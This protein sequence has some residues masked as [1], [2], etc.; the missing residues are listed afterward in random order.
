M[1]IKGANKKPK[2]NKSKSK[3]KTRPKHRNG[4]GDSPR[5]NQSNEFRNNYDS[6][7]WSN[8]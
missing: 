6:I 1:E 2:S 8:K 7:N 5:N 3:R 4:K